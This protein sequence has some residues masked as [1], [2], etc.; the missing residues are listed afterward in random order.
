MMK[1]ILEDDRVFNAELVNDDEEQ[2]SAF[3]FYMQSYNTGEFTLA[4]GFRR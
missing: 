1:A 2:G 4:R 3:G